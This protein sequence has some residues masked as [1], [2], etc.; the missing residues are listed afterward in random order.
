ML[1]QRYGR[2]SSGRDL[3][4]G[5]IHGC[6]SKLQA[7]LD[8]I[9]FNPEVDRLFSVGDLI[10]RG[11]ES[12]EFEAWLA[13]PWFRAIMGNHEEAAIAY[14]QGKLDDRTYVGGF[15]GGWNVSNSQIERERIAALLAALPMGIE[16]ETASG[17]VGILHADCPSPSWAALHENLAAGGLRAQSTRDCCTWSRDRCERMNDAPVEGVRAVV[18]GHTPFEKM[19]SLGNVLY[20]DTFAWRNGHFTIL[21]ADTLRPAE[22]P[23]DRV[24]DWS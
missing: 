15:G 23:P 4:V 6:F 14:S 17:L 24:L 7:A 18:V 2:N 9:K 16:L 3:I 12:A 22:R 19:T 5:D 10:D 8:K 13:K 11:P 21:D 1:I 20:I